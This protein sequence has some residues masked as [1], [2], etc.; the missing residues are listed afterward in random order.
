MYCKKPKEYIKYF[1]CYNCNCLGFFNET[2]GLLTVLGWKL[3]LSKT[4]PCYM[5]SGKGFVA[6][7]KI[8]TKKNNYK[9]FLTH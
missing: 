6:S 3:S 4:R 7:K 1:S 2:R 5:C 9:S 8:I